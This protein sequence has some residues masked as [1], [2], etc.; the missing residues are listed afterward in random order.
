MS[1]IYRDEAPLRG[2]GQVVDGAPDPAAGGRVPITVIEPEGYARGGIVVLHESRQFADVLLE[3][4][5]SL[6]GEGWIMVAPN[7]FHRF[8]RQGGHGDGAGT[9]N[10]RDL[11]AVTAR[12]ANGDDLKISIGDGAVPVQGAAADVLAWLTGRSDGSGL[13]TTGDVPLPDLPSWG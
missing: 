11:A 9:V 7:L 5:K 3:M 8:D 10:D 12:L 6:A 4:M 1:G 2:S 13:T